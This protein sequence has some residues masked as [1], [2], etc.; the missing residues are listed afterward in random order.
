M[1]KYISALEKLIN[2]TSSFDLQQIEF[3]NLIEFMLENI[4]NTNPYIRDSLIYAGFCELILNEKVTIDQTI[5]I[6][7]TCI[8]DQHLYLNIHM[9]EKNDAVFVRSFSALVIDLILIKDIENRAL[10]QDLIIKTLERGS[11]YLNFESDYRGYVSEK[12]WAHSVAHGSDLLTRVISHPLSDE[13]ISISDCLNT[14]KKCL[15]TDYAYIDDEDE[16][17]LAI[18]D[19]LFEKGL[20]DEN[21]KAWLI[22]LHIFEE[23]D[24]LKKYR[25]QWN[26]KKFTLTLYRHLLKMQI[27]KETSKWIYSTY[28][29][30]KPEQNTC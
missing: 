26:I 11:N 12:G 9:P 27:S 19:V 5:S 29:S 18:I 13:I 23:N 28:I 3:T 15:S 21:L 6:L 4:G 14:I 1:D 22:N 10:P 7:R 25:I 8:D 30:N 16:R 20:S 17:I 24:E 2:D